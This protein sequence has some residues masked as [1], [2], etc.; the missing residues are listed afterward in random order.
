MELEVEDG[1]SPESADHVAKEV[2]DIEDSAD[3]DENFNE[4]LQLDE[5]IGNASGSVK[6]LDYEKQMFLDCAY[7]DGLVICGK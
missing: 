7:S 5:M 2:V 3:E 6:M 1:E 4:I